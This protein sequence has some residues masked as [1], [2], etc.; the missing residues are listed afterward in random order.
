MY[1]RI[2]IAADGKDDARRLVRALKEL[3]P[4]PD[5]VEVTVLQVLPPP[6]PPGVTNPLVPPLTGGDDLILLGEANARRDLQPLADELAGAGF[7][8]TVDVAI[9]APG[10]EIC[11]YA[12]NGG[13]QVIVMGRRGLGRVQ[14]VLLGSV[15]EYVLRH[16]HLPV[17]VVQQ[18][19]GTA[20]ES[21]EAAG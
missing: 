18:P 11:R 17:L 4:R 6:V 9:G 16:A 3:M 7:A 2:L 15:S 21:Q 14:E 1:R 12:Q 13:F 20:A 19:R 5:G 8:A 10:P